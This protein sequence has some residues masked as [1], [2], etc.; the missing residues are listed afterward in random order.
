MSVPE[1]PS[2][3]S[4]LEDMFQASLMMLY[5]LI[6]KMCLTLTNSQYM[7]QNLLNYMIDLHKSFKLQM[8]PQAVSVSDISLSKAT[9]RN[10]FVSTDMAPDISAGLDPV[11]GI[12]IAFREHSNLEPNTSHL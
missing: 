1:I 7:I 6:E 9:S 10:I 8:K 11:H 3:I 12:S 2:N 5:I 4:S